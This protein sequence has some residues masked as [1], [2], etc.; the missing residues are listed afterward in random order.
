MLRWVNRY[1]YDAPDNIGEII[2]IDGVGNQDTYNPCLCY[3][4]GSKILAFRCEDR[5]SLIEDKNNYHPSIK[6]AKQ[7]E[8]GRWQVAE[9]IKPFEM[10]EDPLFVSIK[11]GD[12]D[13]VILGGV[14]AKHLPT[15]GFVADTVFYKGISLATLERDEPFATILG[16]KDERLKQLPD[17]R[18]LLCRRPLD[19]KG[20]GH[21]AIHVLDNLEELIT[22]NDV[23]P[24][25]I[26]EIDGT[27]NDDWV[28]INNAYILRDKQGVEWVGLLGHIGCKDENGDKHYAATTYKIKMDDLLNGQSQPM[29]PNIIVTRSSFPDGPK[30]QSFLGD[31]V[32][33]GSFERLDD[34]KY[35]LWAGLSDARIGIID[36][37]DP[38]RLNQ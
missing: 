36:L 12:S 23:L 28:G 34:G 3:S 37:D 35:R 6:F 14:R 9:E 19:D 16:I 20:I 18:I 21:I 1:D 10:L 26:F 38:F 32:F 15:G 17:G 4:D 7:N 22:I 13:L 8:I 30:K 29:A 5:D 11:D 31:V 33:P 25:Q 2:D 24:R 27:H